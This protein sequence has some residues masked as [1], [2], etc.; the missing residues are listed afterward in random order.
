MELGAK[1][2]NEWS[3]FNWVRRTRLTFSL[4]A[5]APKAA[6]ESTYMTLSMSFTH[7]YYSAPSMFYRMVTWAL[8]N[9]A[10]R[11]ISN[12]RQFWGFGGRDLPDFG[13]VCRGSWVVG[14]PWKF[15]ISYNVQEYEMKTHSRKI[16]SCAY[17]IKIPGRYTLNPLLI[18]AS[19]C[20][21]FRDHDP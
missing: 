21:T 2:V 13:R 16:K 4:G 7:N 20:W 17:E 6:R 1:H 10:K 18:C 12:W 8:S 14:S 5:L 11:T 9:F 3:Q 19:V 15:I